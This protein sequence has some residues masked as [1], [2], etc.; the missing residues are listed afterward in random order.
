MIDRFFCWLADAL[1]SNAAIV[2]FTLIAF[3]PL[4]YHLPNGV[5]EWQGWLSQVCIQLISLA[6]IQKGGN[7]SERRVIG[8]LQETHDT[9]MQEMA[10]LKTLHRD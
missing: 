8:L 3:V 7:T 10:E 9:V 6:V 2:M 4:A 1:G 5:L